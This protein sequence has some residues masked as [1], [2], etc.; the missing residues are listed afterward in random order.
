MDDVLTQYPQTLYQPL[1]ICFV[2]LSLFS[3]GRFYLYSLGLLRWRRI[4]RIIISPRNVCSVN[5]TT[6]NKLFAFVI[7]WNPSFNILSNHDEYI[8]KLPAP[9]YNE[10]P[11]H[12]VFH[13]PAGYTGIEKIICSI[14]MIKSFLWWKLWP[15][16][17]LHSQNYLLNL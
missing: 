7:S 13:K 15:G 3:T 14:K 11:T 10:I 1:G 2:F 16:P 12:I 6:Q 8:C 9:S 4:N 17:W 5:E